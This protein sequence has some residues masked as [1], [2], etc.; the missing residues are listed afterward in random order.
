MRQKDETRLWLSYREAFGVIAQQYYK[1]MLRY[2][3]KFRVD[4]ESATEAPC[5]M[6]GCAYNLS[7]FLSRCLLVLY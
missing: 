5:Q 4:S 1:A 6:E 2:R 3:M 7:A